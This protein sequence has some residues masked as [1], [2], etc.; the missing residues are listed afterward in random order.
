RSLPLAGVR[1]GFPCPVLEVSAVADLGPGTPLLGH[2]WRDGFDPPLGLVDT[3]SVMGEVT[4]VIDGVRIPGR[5]VTA[6]AVSVIVPISPAIIPVTLVVVL[7]VGFA[8][9]GFFLFLFLL[10]FRSEGDGDGDGAVLGQDRPGFGGL[11]ENFVLGNG[12]VMCF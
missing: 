6:A 7:L 5:H 9:V 12:V 10:L 2:V 3:S 4:G 11:A 1:N 8:V